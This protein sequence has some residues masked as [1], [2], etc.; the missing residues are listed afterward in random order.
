MFTINI[1]GDNYKVDFWRDE[2]KGKTTH[3][4]IIIKNTE[5]VEQIISTGIA[6]CYFKDNFNKNKGRKFALAAAL[7]NLF[8]GYPDY[9]KDRKI[10]WDTYFKIRHGKF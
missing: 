4:N 3:C 10:F 8:W 1:N 2:D 9:K 5:K 7:D 6:T